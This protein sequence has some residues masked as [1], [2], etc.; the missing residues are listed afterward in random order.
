MGDERNL[1]QPDISI[2]YNLEAISVNGSVRLAMQNRPRRNNRGEKHGSDAGEPGC[3]CY[4]KDT[5]TLKNRDLG[6][7]T[8][9]SALVRF[10]LPRTV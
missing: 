3:S 1:R 2:V 5:L 9:H 4:G 6:L 8:R 10:S 7:A